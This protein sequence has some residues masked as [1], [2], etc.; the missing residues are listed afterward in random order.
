MKDKTN[1]VLL[2]L[3]AVIVANMMFLA[4]MSKKEQLETP[5]N[6]SSTSEDSS[7][8]SFTSSDSNELLETLESIENSQDILNRVENHF[9]LT[10][11]DSNEYYTRMIASMSDSSAFFAYYT[12]ITDSEQEHIYAMGLR[13]GT[14]IY[15]NNYRYI[16]R[17]DELLESESDLIYKF[18]PTD[19]TEE[20]VMKEINQILVDKGLTLNDLKIAMQEKYDIEKEGTD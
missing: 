15:D 3:V 20:E 17:G 11:D 18:N 9:V 14:L 7:I 6:T 12:E 13:V 2:G 1:L 19:R 4:S 10:V 5:N 16:L 8:E